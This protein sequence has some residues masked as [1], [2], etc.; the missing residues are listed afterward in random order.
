MHISCDTNVLAKF[1]MEHYPLT[2]L[3]IL[4]LGRNSGKEYPHDD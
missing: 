2:K 3:G 1:G 4:C